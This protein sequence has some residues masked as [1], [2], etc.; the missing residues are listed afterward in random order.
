MS[1]QVFLRRVTVRY[2]HCDAAGIIFYPN[3]FFFINQAVEDWFKLEL[4]CDWLTYHLDRRLGIPTAHLEVDFSAPSYM[5]DVLDWEMRLTHL[6]TKSITLE[7]RALCRDEERIRANHRLVTA[8]LD[9]IKPVPIPDDIR[10]QM[11]RFLDSD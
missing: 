7:H 3:Y 1:G 11:A 9:G 5:N 6:G 2:E 8:S 10:E 4:G